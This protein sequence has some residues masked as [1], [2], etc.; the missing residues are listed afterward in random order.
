MIHAIFYTATAAGTV[1][2]NQIQIS[3]AHPPTGEGWATVAA[4]PFVLG[5]RQR[6]MVREPSS[7]TPQPGTH[8]SRFSAN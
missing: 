7:T 3:R 8:A 4:G 5:F 2:E 6:P 1:L